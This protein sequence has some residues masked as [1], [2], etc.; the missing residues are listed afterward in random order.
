MAVG[1]QTTAPIAGECSHRPP[2][3]GSAATPPRLRQVLSDAVTYMAGHVVTPFLAPNVLMFVSFPKPRAAPRPCGADLCRRHGPS[4]PCGPARRAATRTGARASTRPAR[5]GSHL[6]SPRGSTRLSLWARSSCA[7]HAWRLSRQ[8]SAR[9]SSASRPPHTPSPASRAS[10]H[11]RHSARTVHRKH[12]FFASSARRTA[13]GPAPTGKNSSGST[14]RHRARSIHSV[15]TRSCV[16]PLAGSS[17]RRCQSRPSDWRPW[18]SL[19]GGGWACAPRCSTERWYAGGQTRYRIEGGVGLS[20][21]R[22]QLG[23]GY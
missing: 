3:L 18:R 9:R 20:A 14:S 16:R 12:T 10:A 8:R 2:V 11:R 15:I 22:A 6:Y 5:H 17:A 1:Q 19:S 21:V 13:A 4:R 23:C 7:G